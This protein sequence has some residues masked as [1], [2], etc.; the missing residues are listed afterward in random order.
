[1]KDDAFEELLEDMSDLEEALEEDSDSL[2]DTP[3]PK[4]DKQPKTSGT[5]NHEPSDGFSVA[6]EAAKTSQEAA[7]RSHDVAETNLKLAE[8]LK[9]QERDLTEAN[10]NW[11]QS[12]RTS[13][14]TLNKVKGQFVLMMAVTLITSFIALGVMSFLYYSVQQKEQAMKGE[15]LDLLQNEQA[16]FNKEMTVKV[17][18][19]T[20]MMEMV[21]YQLEQ[22]QVGD[23]GNPNQTTE[24]PYPPQNQKAE[25]HS[26]IIHD[27]QTDNQKKPSGPETPSADTH[28]KNANAHSEQT[29]AMKQT[30]VEVNFDKVNQQMATEMKSLEQSLAK[31]IDKLHHQQAD[32]LAKLADIENW[33]KNHMEITHKQLSQ[34]VHSPKTATM[35]HVSTTE[36]TLPKQQVKQLNN[37]HWWV[38]KHD[39][40]LKR[41]EATL[42]KQ[43]STGNNGDKLENRLN[44]IDTQMKQV[45]TQQSLI[46]AQLHKLQGS[47]KQLIDQ[48]NASY[49]YKAKESPHP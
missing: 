27:P 47:V 2:Q 40:A 35:N 41:I 39:K 26:S 11:R 29:A 30:S 22:N 34:S 1:M 7:S 46:E 16:L 38:S 45:R 28:Q 3:V 42:K 23:S 10:F 20:S 17:D 36:V 12:V 49:R 13:T 14:A 21:Q 6:L 37:I 31:T 24:S 32:I 25:T 19:I 44:T 8:Q 15:I 5:S 43:S 9:A 4:S 33:Q 18:Q 48:A